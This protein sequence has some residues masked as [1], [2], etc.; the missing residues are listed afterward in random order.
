MRRVLLAIGCAAVAASLGAGCAK[1]QARIAPEEPLVTLN[2]PPP[3]PR[4]V[5]VYARPTTEPAPEPEEAEEPAVAEP[6]QARPAVPPPPRPEPAVASPPAGEPGLLRPVGSEKAQTSIR[7]LLAQAARDL[8]RVNYQTLGRDARVQHDIARRF[9][10]QAET[11][12]AAGNLMF[13]GKLADKAATMAA[14]LV[15]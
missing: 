10:Q 7:N 4:V 3:P 14:V 9:M 13:A 8:S 1:V 12:L 11:A 15:R 2:T 6:P 5:E